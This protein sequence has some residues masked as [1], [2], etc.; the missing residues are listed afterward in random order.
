IKENGITD[1]R[2]IQPGQRI[3]VAL[4]IYSTE[5]KEV[6]ASWY[7]H[8]HHGKPM[9]NGEPFNMYSSTIAHKELPLGTKVELRDPDTGVKVR[10]VVADRGP[11]VQ[12]RDVDLSYGLARRLALVDRGVGRLMMRILG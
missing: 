5:E 9:A 2:K 12:C 3:Q 11:Y 7:G 8:E 10:A 4:P 6:V 1:P